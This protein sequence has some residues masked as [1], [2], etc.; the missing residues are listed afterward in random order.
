MIQRTPYPITQSRS[1]FLNGICDHKDSGMPRQSP[2]CESLHESLCIWTGWRRRER[3]GPPPARARR[4]GG[5]PPTAK[6][7]RAPPHPPAPPPTRACP[8]SPAICACTVVAT[9]C[10]RAQGTMR[11]GLLART[12]LRR[13]KNESFERLRSITKYSLTWLL[14]GSTSIHG[15]RVHVHD[16]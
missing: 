12:H 5:A 4:P 13:A 11:E 2:C 7:A 1:A 10:E 15:L 9:I 16:K 14:D 6:T 3:F 8:P